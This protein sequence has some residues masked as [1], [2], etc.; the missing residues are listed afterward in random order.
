MRSRVGVMVVM[1]ATA[2]ALS[3]CGGSGGGSKTLNFY[4]FKEP[5]GG[6]RE[7]AK[8]C[9][10]QSR[11]RYNIKFQFLPSIADQQ[12][13]QLVRRLGAEDKTIDMIGMDVIWTGEF[14]N[15]GW[16][17]PVPQDVQGPATSKV[18]QSMIETA[19]A[20]GRLYA[21][22]IWSN[23]QLLWYRK[24]KSPQPPK[25]W[26]EMIDRAVQQ[27]TAIA[28]Q[29]NRYEGLVVWTNAMIES[30][31]TSILKGDDQVGLEKAPT[32]KAIATMGKLGASPAAGPSIDTSEE[33]PARMA[34]EAGDAFYELNYPF[35][36]ASAKEGAPDIFKQMGATKYPQVDP[37]KPSR[38]PLGGI[39]LAVGRYSTKKDLA[40]EAIRC[41]IKA[42]NQI[43][44]ME[45]GGLPPVRE[46]LYDR[47][48]VKKYYPGFAATIRD[49]IRDAAPRPAASAAYQDLSLAIQDAIHPVSKINERGV[50][51][52][53]DNLRENVEK[54]IKREG[55]LG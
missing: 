12:R 7:V 27:K 21:V 41:M 51:K 48:E 47:P 24:D 26:D 3:A 9:S 39:N 10:Q 6:P 15:A 31:G 46:D 54:G 18:F 50:G 40:W 19:K 16:I 52:V 36:Y 55:L 22:P 42:E 25:T 53:Y 28:V 43:T 29:G 33:D 20:N 2:V 4:I 37:S 30:A 32:E 17:E 35:V 44:I 49:S 8:T 5:G 1:L 34:F 45:K 38:P 14:A 13:E 11:G 23:T